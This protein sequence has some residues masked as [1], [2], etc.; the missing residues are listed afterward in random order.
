MQSE[1]K[2]SLEHDSAASSDIGRSPGT[3]DGSIPAD[4]Q[5]AIGGSPV[6]RQSD[7]P[8]GRDFVIGGM[9]RNA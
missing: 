3:A 8:S 6:A 1:A 9:G 4:A 2:A 5:P 7:G